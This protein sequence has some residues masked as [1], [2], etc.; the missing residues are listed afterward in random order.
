M[1]AG[2]LHH[3]AHLRHHCVTRP[4]GELSRRFLNENRH[5]HPHCVT[6]RVKVESS[7]RRARLRRAHARARPRR[8][9]CLSAK[10]PSK[11]ILFDVFLL[12]L[13]PRR[14]RPP[15]SLS[16]TRRLA[17]HP[18]PIPSTRM[19][20]VPPTADLARPLPSHRAQRHPSLAPSLRF[21]LLRRRTPASPG[22]NPHEQL[23]LPAS[24]SR[25]VRWVS[26]HEHTRV[27]S[28]ER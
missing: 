16:L 19:G 5:L 14:H 11:P 8:L 22:G 9:R 6:R 17:A 24:R 3:P 18:L 7:Q 27:N 25:P 13:A 1:S 26:S 4:R 20:L 21:V 12:P 15:H 10:S 28:R 2:S 23:P